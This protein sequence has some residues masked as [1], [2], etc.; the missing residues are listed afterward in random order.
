[1]FGNPTSKSKNQHG[2]VANGKS[3]GAGKFPLAT[4][5]GPIILFVTHKTRLR[6]SGY[7][8]VK[9]VDANS[10]KQLLLSIN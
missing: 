1:M 4:Q 6:P 8:E 2:G 10:N 9:K 5:K 7:G 3:P